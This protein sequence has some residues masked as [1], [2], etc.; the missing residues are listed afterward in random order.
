ME[1]NVKQCMARFVTLC[2][3]RAV[4]VDVIRMAMAQFSRTDLTGFAQSPSLQHPRS[5]DPIVAFCVGNEI[6]GIKRSPFPIGGF[7]YRRSSAI[8]RV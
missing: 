6:E 2:G 4:F 5:A 8:C 3:S 7:P 1:T